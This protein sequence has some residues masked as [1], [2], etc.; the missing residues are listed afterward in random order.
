MNHVFCIGTIDLG[1]ERLS[2]LKDE[3]PY[4]MERELIDPNFSRKT[5]HQMREGGHPTITTLTYN[6]S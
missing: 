4:S 2:G 6:C 3:M 1:G 5:G